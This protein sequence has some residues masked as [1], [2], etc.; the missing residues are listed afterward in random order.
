MD[1]LEN[2]V[3]LI[4]DCKDPLRSQNWVPRWMAEKRSPEFVADDPRVPSFGAT[5]SSWKQ[6]IQLRDWTRAYLYVVS[7]RV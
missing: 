7:Y 5:N 1:N 3:T 4:P 6:H 2:R